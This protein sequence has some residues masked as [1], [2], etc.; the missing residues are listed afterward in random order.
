MRPFRV[1]VADLLHQP[2]A[3]KREHVE[4]DLGDLAVTGS[5]LLPGSPVVIDVTLE[6]VHEGILASGT[7]RAEWAGECRRCLN[8]ATG[9]LETDF[10]ELFE[11]RPIEGEGYPL[12]HEQVDLEPLARETVLLELPQAPLCK[13][14]CLGLCARCGAD[15]NEGPCDCGPEPDPRW[16]AL[17]ALRTPQTTAEE[18]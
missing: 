11:E 8:P 17:D 7:L 2:G 10:R 3:R 6:S 1:G 12:S 16:A 13:D 5:R 14:D 15:L 9:E 18:D 4:G